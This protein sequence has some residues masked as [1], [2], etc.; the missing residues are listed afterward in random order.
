MCT[1]WF[2]SLQQNS[3]VKFYS[4]NSQRSGTFLGSLK[5]WPKPTNTCSLFYTSPGQNSLP[6]STVKDRKEMIP[7][8]WNCDFSVTPIAPQLPLQGQ[9]VC[10]KQFPSNFPS[11]NC[12]FSPE[13]LSTYVGWQYSTCTFFFCFT[14]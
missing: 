5:F 1:M 3:G 9:G 7:L 12:H 11:Q 14:P 4:R 13:I 2:V 6:A 10:T 8:C